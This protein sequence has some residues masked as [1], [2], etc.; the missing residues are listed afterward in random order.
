MGTAYVYRTVRVRLGH[1][2]ERA[3]RAVWK[4]RG[5]QSQAFNLGTEIA[6]ASLDRDEGVPPRF[7]AFNELTARR[8]SGDMPPEVSSVLQR[9]GVSAGLDRVA[10]WDRAVRGN[11]WAVD[12]WSKR[13]EQAACGND[14]GYDDAAEYCAARLDRAAPTSAETCGAGHCPS[15]PVS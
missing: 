8:Q 13:V 12:Y 7:T 1:L 4:H 2:S 3:R 14:Q 9:G 6:L 11:A 5:E 15:V 10:K